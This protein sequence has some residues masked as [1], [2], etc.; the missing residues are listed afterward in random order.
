METSTSVRHEHQFVVKLGKL[1]ELRDWGFSNDEIFQIVGPR[2]SLDRRKSQGGVL[3]PLESDRAFRLE[4]IAEHA[5]RVFGDREKAR[6]WL[7]SPNRALHSARPMDL[8]ESETGAHQVHEVLHQ[9]DFG[10]FG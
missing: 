7:R 3:S 2:R 1:D 6:R 10:M 4:R 5:D 9:I 8:L